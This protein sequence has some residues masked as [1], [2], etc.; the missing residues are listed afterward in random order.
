MALQ[1]SVQSAR[2]VRHVL[3]ARASSTSSAVP[4]APALEDK[5]FHARL[6]DMVDPNSA[7]SAGNGKYGRGLLICKDRSS[8]QRVCRVHFENTVLVADDPSQG[9]EFGASHEVL[10]ASKD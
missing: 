3:V 5:D 7:V 8:L 2:R 6:R 4:S 9:K 10:C 1:S